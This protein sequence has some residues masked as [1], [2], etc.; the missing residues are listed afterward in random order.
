MKKHP[1]RTALVLALL[2]AVAGSGIATST[3]SASTTTGVTCKAVTTGATFS[4][5]H[6]VTTSGGGSGFI[7]ESLPQNTSTPITIA[8]AATT[9]VKSTIA[10]VP[11]EIACSAAAGTGILNTQGPVGAQEMYSWGT[12]EITFSGCS[13]VSPTGFGCTVGSSTLKTNPLLFTTKEQ[14]MGVKLAP[15]TGTTIAEVKID[16]CTGV[17]SVFNGAWPLSGSVVLT[18]HG[19]TLN[20][21]HAETTAQGTLTFIGGNVAGLATSLTLKGTVAGW[22]ISFTT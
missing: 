6:C 2:G 10:S 9:S 19:A 15:E 12:A 13:L 11:V 16:G 14:G 8:G 17:A 20:S 22:G 3:A 4:D 18:P 7:H 21:T 1:I 5:S